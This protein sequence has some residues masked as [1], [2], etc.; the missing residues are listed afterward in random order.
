[1]NWGAKECL[2]NVCGGSEYYAYVTN[3]HSNVLTI[4]DPDPDGNGSASDAAI[5][6]EVVL[7]ASNPT[8]GTG[9]Q[10]ILPIPLVKDGWI[11]DTVVEWVAGTTSPEVTGFLNELTACQRAANCP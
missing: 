4:V 6:G 1:M 7:G 9:G 11:Q 5:V 3:Q 8:D 2:N 10:G